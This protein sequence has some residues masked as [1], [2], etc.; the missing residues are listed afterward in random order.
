M[1]RTAYITVGVKIMIEA[2]TTVEVVAHSFYF[3][4]FS[5]TVSILFLNYFW[6]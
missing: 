2:T 5:T 3:F 4:F 6:E 1:P